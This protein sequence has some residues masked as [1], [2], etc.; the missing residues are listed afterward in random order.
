M[1]KQNIKKNSQEY[2]VEYF[3]GKSVEMSNIYTGETIKLLKQYTV[4]RNDSLNKDQV[5]KN[6]S[7]ILASQE[8]IIGELRIFIHANLI[9]ILELV[10]R[11]RDTIN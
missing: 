7:A 3:K 9:P 10:E 5:I 2:A 11:E 6:A 8:A 4:V 1:V